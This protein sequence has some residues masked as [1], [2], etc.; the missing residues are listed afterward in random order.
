MLDKV[1]DTLATALADVPDGAT[2]L[3]GG[4]G[5]SGVPQELVC[6]LLDQGARELT[7]VNNNAGNG[8]VGLSQLFEARRVRKLVCSY[9][10]SV[11]GVGNAEAFAEEYRTGRV[12]LECVPQGVLAE[13]MRAAAAG[14]G[15]FFTPTGYGTL[16]A[17]GKETRVI[18]GRGYV[19]EDPLPGDYGLVKAQR[20]DRWGNLAFNG[21]ECNF[22]PVVAMAS[23]VAVAQV[24]DIVE[25]GELPPQAVQLPGIFVQRVVQVRSVS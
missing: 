4:F 3:I 10:R 13:R 5:E 20:A 7:I 15:P 6:T 22:N 14:N 1:I 9:A 8:P 17:E 2:I 18:D 25:L 24:D 16:L 21:A 23:R 19:L 12:E 11:S